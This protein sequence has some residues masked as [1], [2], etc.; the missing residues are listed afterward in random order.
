MDLQEPSRFPDRAHCVQA[1]RAD[2][3]GALV[4][5]FD[6][7]EGVI[8][9]DGNSLGALP[10]SVPPRIEE[11]TRREWGEG[12]IRSWN[13]AG[14]IDL[15]RRV[16]AKIASLIGAQADEVIVADSTSVNV[17]KLL[18]AALAIRQDRSIVLTDSGNFPTDLYIAQGLL[19]QLGPSK[20]L[21]TVDRRDIVEAI[22]DQVAVVM[23][24]QVDYRSGEKFDLAAVSA[25]AHRA[26][27]LVLW[28]LAHSA[29]AF[30]V[31]LG[32]AQADFAV[33]CGY[34]YLNGGPGAPAFAYVARR[35]HDRLDQPLSGWLG[36]AE[37]FAFESDYRPASGVN[38]LMCGSPAVLSMSALDAALA[39]F[40]RAEPRGG[41]A[42]LEAKVQ[43]LTELFIDR[44]ESRCAG[45]GLRVIS[46]RNPNRRGN[47]V[48]IAASDPEHGY[49][50]MQ[51][52]IAA[53]VIGD[54]RAPD[55]LRF[56][57]APLYLRH[58]DVWD[59]VETL[60]R[61]IDERVWDEPRWRQRKA[62]T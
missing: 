32:A 28:D 37:P 35:H 62:V 34:K 20:Q 29:G 55:I 16:G 15:P 33:G 19:R 7:P 11:V 21:L 31:D 52:L 9:L 59:A 25:R 48:S 5:D 54:F 27:A 41:M 61:L 22:N 39:V 43:R 17:Y 13:D 14:W 60:A 38:R 36:H 24:T 30:Q 2:P 10:R 12:L 8:Y 49:A 47:Q 53:G 46:P 1:D 45:S 50:L 23:L 42:G 51:A 4:D 40:E 6:L 44:F 18:S 58:V 3:F 26:G 57:F 56:G